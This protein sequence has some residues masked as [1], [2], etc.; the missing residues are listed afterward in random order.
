MKYGELLVT[1][2]IEETW[3]LGDSEKL[4]F[5]G[6]NCKT[7]S[8]KKLRIDVHNKTLKDPWSDRESRKH[9]F[10]NTEKIYERALEY[11]HINLNK[12]HGINKSKLYWQI[13]VGPWLKIFINS[14]YHPWEVIKDLKKSNWN[15]KTIAINNLEEIQ[16]SYDIY[17]FYKK[18]LTHAW[19]HHL[20]C[21]IIEEF[22]ESEIF[23][24]I[25]KPKELLIEE[26]FEDESSTDFILNKVKRFINFLS[27]KLNNPSYFFHKTYLTKYHQIALAI[28]L[29][30]MPFFSKASIKLKKSSYD[31]SLRDSL[32]SSSKNNTSDPFENFL[33][34]KIFLYQKFLIHTSHL[35]KHHM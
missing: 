9:Y 17:D 27:H 13:L 15:G 6:E 26:N 1:T 31:E 2:P 29:G 28:K 3:A 4:I 14:A 32:S 25:E 7:F 8:N 11:I 21:Q 23:D 24:H 12:Y 20:C 35:V 19:N 30:V 34:S 18:R 5:L 10:E 33:Y 16:K 22:Y